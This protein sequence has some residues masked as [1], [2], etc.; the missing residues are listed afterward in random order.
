MAST[1]YDPPAG[2]S[3]ILDALD[4]GIVLLDEQA[5]I[6]DWN[7]WMERSSDLPSPTMVGRNL[8]EALPE[9]K[10]TRL[11]SAVRD[12]LDAGV[13]SVLSHTLNPTL[14]PL[15]G[16]DGS[17]LLHNVV[18]RPLP[19]GQGYHCLIQVNDITA[20]V[21]RERILR[22]QRDA[23]YRAIVDTAGDAMV[24][25][26]TRGAIQWLNGAAARQFGY[27]ADEL[28]GESVRTLL[29]E[30]AP[31]WVA[32]SEQE[33]EAE[34]GPR[35]VELAGR[36][37]D[38][39]RVDLEL[40]LAR[41]RAEGRSFITGIL[42][43]VTERRRSREELQ[44]NALAMRQLAEQTQATL[45]ALPA[46]IA[47]LDR[48][49]RIVSVNRAWAEAGSASAFL[50]AGSAVG[51]N[52][53]MACAGA[54]GDADPLN[55]DQAD[56]VI[57]GLQGLLHGGGAVS[58]EYEGP[59]EEKGGE[60]RWFRCQ[61]APMAAGPFGGAV[62]MH[63]DTTQIKSM[64]AALRKV[65]GQKSTLLREVN[66]RVKNSLQLVS[67]LLTLQT[68]SLTD[69]GAKAHFQDARS[70]IE[71]IARVHNRLYQTEQFQ[72]IEFGSYLDELCNDL[73]RASGGE[74]TCH[75]EL[76]A[77]A[78]DLSID[79]AAP[80][81]LVANELI[82][83]AIKHRGVGKAFVTV[84]LE[85]AGNEAVLT[86]TDQGPGLPPDFDHRRSK[87]LG[88]RLITSLASQ[89]EARVEPLPTE[90]GAAFRVT[91][92]LPAQPEPSA[93]PRRAEVQ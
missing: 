7:A 64:E 56:A 62:V 13:P 58:V 41:W 16:N 10:G 48:E 52:Y 73:E 42:R 44:L 46:Y 76:R 18:L 59:T 65:V 23:R 53:L 45:D 43:D 66:H 61:A 50:G 47:V 80:L 4:A 71:A 79:Q 88:M 8:F 84:D 22:E 24:T 87:S 81:G 26:D 38:G 32:L 93:L 2:I 11:H 29:A 20:S 82:T 75:I 17:R 51:D 30:G 21:K 34:R 5:L 85:R 49:G 67:S 69:E 35:V 19:V 90:R 68:M 86:V 77:A 25:T 57:G 72:S 91:V 74:A 70:R 92:P 63:I 60:P 40:S 89:I 54:D 6:R 37:R 12:V 27:A 15:H 28:I 83:N 55:L 1:P 31:D 3:G 33:G 14:F 9:L 78:V 39:S 36:R